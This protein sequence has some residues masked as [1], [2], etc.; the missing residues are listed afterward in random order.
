MI[1]VCDNH[2][3]SLEMIHNTKI[4]SSYDICVSCYAQ[5]S[6]TIVENYKKIMS[7]NGTN[8]RINQ[9]ELTGKILTGTYDYYYCVVIKVDVRITGQPNICVS[10]QKRSL[11]SDKPCQC[12]GVS[13]I[14]PASINTI[15]RFLEFSVC[16]QALQTFR[17]KAEA[18]RV[19]PTKWTTN[20]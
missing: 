8:R 2:V 13:F 20:T 12:G 11:E 17:Q 7:P 16:E 6:Q 1:Q 19:H 10:C 15:T 9:C 4:I 5:F 14:R 3:P 18:V